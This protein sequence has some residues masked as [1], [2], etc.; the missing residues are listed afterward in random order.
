MVDGLG[1]LFPE[2]WLN[3][4]NLKITDHSLINKWAAIMIH[5]CITD[6]NLIFARNI[7]EGLHV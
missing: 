2:F 5:L 1:N 3:I 4:K 6:M 7:L